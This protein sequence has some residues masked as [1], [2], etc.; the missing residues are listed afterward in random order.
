MRRV[1]LFFIAIWLWGASGASG[2]QRLSI[3]ED[4]EIRVFLE[5]LGEPLFA[6]LGRGEEDRIQYVL[7]GDNT[8]NAFVIDER[9]IFLNMGTL[10]LVPTAGALS[11]VLAHEMGHIAGHHTV[12]GGQHARSLSTKSGLGLLLGITLG[13]L[14]SPDIFVLSTIVPSVS[15]SQYAVFSQAQEAK[16]DQYGVMLLFRVGY[17]PKDMLVVSDVLRNMEMGLP[18][19]YWRSHPTGEWRYKRV[20]SAVRQFG[21]PKVS[22]FPKGIE[23]T[24]KRLQGKV[25]GYQ[26]APKEVYRRFSGQK[27]LKAQY[28]LTIAYYRDHQHK[29]ALEIINGLLVRYPKDPWFLETKAQI[30]ESIGQFDKAVVVYQKALEAAGK[31]AK[32][33]KIEAARTLLASKDSHRWEKARVLAKEAAY[34][35]KTGAAW[36]ILIRVYAHQKKPIKLALSRAEKALNEG[37]IP[38]ATYQSGLVKKKAKVNSREWVRADDILSMLATL[39]PMVAKGAK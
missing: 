24:F 6:G 19:A 30:F 36:G 18:V 32:V 14:V 21:V 35:D 12:W 34:T 28:A 17:S 29:K 10:S 15:L 7:L 5:T 37:N 1:F 27:T 23:E 39:K 25:I 9:H 20:K 13:V 11:A 38:Y 16:A 2:Q 33:L 4:D 22:H 3:I 8:F 31:S 26:S